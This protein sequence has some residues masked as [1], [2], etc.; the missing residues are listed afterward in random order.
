[1][2][3]KQRQMRRDR[4]YFAEANPAWL[5]CLAWW[6][7]GDDEDTARVDAAVAEAML[8][9][10]ER[11][12][13]ESTSAAVEQEEF[14]ARVTAAAA[15]TDA[16]WL[17]MIMA[18]VYPGTGSSDAEEGDDEDMYNHQV[19]EEEDL[20]AF[21]LVPVEP[22]AAAHRWEEDEVSTHAQQ[23]EEEPEEQEV[24]NEVAQLLQDLL[25][26]SDEDMVPQQADVVDEV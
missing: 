18:A 1:M 21:R 13:E 9:L 3:A 24:T 8:R 26:D 19:Q 2:E 20:L 4:L 14:V 22:L 7:D 16:E 5:N 23:E 25:D 6:V 11:T 12:L 10:H 15:A 17:D